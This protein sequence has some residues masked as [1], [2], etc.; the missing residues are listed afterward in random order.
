MSRFSEAFLAIFPGTRVRHQNS[1]SLTNYHGQQ[2]S[3]EEKQAIVTELEKD[4]ITQVKIAEYLQASWKE[5]R[6][7]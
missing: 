2:F 5:S 4:G 3:N 6:S 7:F 1:I